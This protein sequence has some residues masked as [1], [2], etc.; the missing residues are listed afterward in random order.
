[1]LDYAEWLQRALRFLERLRR[2]PN[3]VDYSVK[4][5][6]IPGTLKLEIA[7]A[8][9]LSE[10]EVQDLSR[11]CRLPIPNPLKRFWIQAS[12]HCHGTYW[13]DTPPDFEEQ[14]AIAF[15]YWSSAHI[16]GGP[17]FESAAEIV[18]LADGFVSWADLFR[19]HSPE[20]AP[21]WQHSL[22]F[23]P[24][25]GDYIG[26]YLEHDSDDPPVVYLCHD[27][28]GNS[29]IIAPTLDEFL[30]RWEEIG[31][32][33]IHFLSSFFHERT[34]LLEPSVFPSKLEAVRSLWP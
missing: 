12:G 16:W 23:V 2:L 32:L 9:P 8:P 33:G 10:Q 7:V 19:K 20:D 27:G 26:L 13:W 14:I 28:G 31:Y 4:G 24:G 6:D 34:G 22:P 15:P 18:R 5:S 1:M 30:M 25:D 11:T 3:T 29:T 21:F 17:H